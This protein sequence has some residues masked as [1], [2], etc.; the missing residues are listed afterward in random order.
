GFSNRSHF[1]RVFQK[2]FGETP[3][4]YRRRHEA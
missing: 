1:Y 2:A 4:D 3:L